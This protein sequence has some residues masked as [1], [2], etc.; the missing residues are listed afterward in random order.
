MTQRP[1]LRR[2]AALLGA[3]V[4][5]LLFLQRF[6][7]VDLFAERCGL[8]LLFAAAS[9]LAIIGTGF[10]AR[11]MRGDS[12]ALDFVVGY[13]L[14]GAICFLVGAVRVAIVTMLPLLVLGMIGGVV[15]I[16]ARRKPLTRPAATLSLQ[17]RGE[18]RATLS[19]GGGE[20]TS[21]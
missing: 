19:L 12:L 8:A 5:L 7:L 13:P 20:G 16:R 18:D 9:A 17:R 21:A 15:A 4:L 14:F 11:R 2:F 6:V 3:A 10:L 1:E